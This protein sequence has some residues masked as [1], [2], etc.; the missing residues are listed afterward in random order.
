MLSEEHL[1]VELCS[2]WEG[3]AQKKCTVDASGSRPCREA[4]EG[5]SSSY[6]DSSVSCACMQPLVQNIGNSNPT[7]KVDL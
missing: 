2:G 5:L 6:S 3:G 1:W 7:R 4:I